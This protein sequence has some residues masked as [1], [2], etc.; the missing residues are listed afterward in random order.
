MKCPHCESESISKNGKYRLK[1][2]TE[3]QHYLC[4]GC[5]KRFSGKTG[6]PM[7]RIRTPAA[8]VAM[9]LKM[10]GEGMSVRASA[11]VMNCSH[12]TIMG[13]EQKMAAQEQQWSPQLPAEQS[14]TIEHDELYTR[15]GENLPPLDVRRL[16]TNRD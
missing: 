12:S 5:E 6:T 2:G 8:A 7:F 15:V 3:I 1:S 4:K 9:A 11:R 13:W 14:I 10:R 16:D